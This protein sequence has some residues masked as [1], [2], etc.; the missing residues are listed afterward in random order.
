MTPRPALLPSL[1]GLALVREAKA[2]LQRLSK[3]PASKP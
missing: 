2:S 3:R 1:I